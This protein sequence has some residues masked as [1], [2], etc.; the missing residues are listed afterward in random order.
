[1]PQAILSWVNT[2]SG[3]LE[4]VEFDVCTSEQH[5]DV[6]T[7][8]QHPVEE[9]A[10]MT[11][12]ARKEPTVCTLEAF[13]GDAP[14][15]RLDRDADYGPVDLQV[16]GFGDPG[17][18]QIPLV[19]PNPPLQISPAGLLQAGIGALVGL[20]AGQPEG[21]FIGKMRR[22]TQ[23]LSA[24]MLLQSAPRDR[25]RDIYEKLLTAQDQRALFTV[26]TAL[27]THRDM[28]LSRL[29]PRQD[30]DTGRGA[31]FEVEFQ[32]I[33]VADSKTVASP[34]PAEKRAQ[35]PKSSGSKNG[36]EDPNA[37]EKGDKFE[38]TAYT[39]AH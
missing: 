8:T 30:D 3:L 24:Q 9:G 37:S 17:T 20:I 28:L 38:S 34:E 11:D 12:H 13:Q 22:A 35:T 27:R 7:I 23:V 39:L 15:K 10:A 6:L 1:M 21:T 25:V 26:D 14:N 31:A 18:Q 33:R 4:Q 32:G 36:G 19:I 2:E 5:E 16:P 29:P